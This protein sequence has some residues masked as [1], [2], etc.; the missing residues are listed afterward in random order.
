VLQVAPSSYCAAKARAPSPRQ[1]RD[2][3]LK[4]EIVRV[5]AEHFGVYGVRKVWRQLRREGRQVARCTVARLMRELGL[6]GAVRGGVKRTTVPAERPGQRPA[7]LVD[8][9]FT[10][11]GP[12]RLWVAD[13]TYVRTWSGF[14]YVAFRHR[15]LLPDDRGLAGRH[16]PARVV[17]HAY[18]AGTPPT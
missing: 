12:D 11:A 5:H 1:V 3:E 2:D 15:R 14:V 18:P 17:A 7:D 8:R 9:D 13:L 10:A 4:A 6:A 16:P